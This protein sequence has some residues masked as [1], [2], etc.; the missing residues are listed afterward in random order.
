MSSATTIKLDSAVDSIAEGWREHTTIH[1]DTAA[2]RELLPQ[3]IFAVWKR[4]KRNP[5]D[6]KATKIPYNPVTG[7]RAKSN[8]PATWG[9]YPQAM[10]AMQ[11]GRFDGIAIM[12]SAP[13]LMVDLDNCRDIHTGR[14]HP[15][16]QAIIDSFQTYWEIS[17]S[18]QGVKA[19]GRGTMPTP[20]GRGKNYRKT[21][22]PGGGVE[23]YQTS[24]MFCLNSQHLPGTP[25]SINDVTE[26]LAA[27]YRRLYPRKVQPRTGAPIRCAV[28]DRARFD[29][30]K[31]YIT[32]MPN[33]ITGS[34][35]HNATFAACCECFRFGLSDAD[36]RALMQWFNSKKTGGEPWSDFELD[37]KLSDA[38]SRVGPEFGCRLIQSRPIARIRSTVTFSFNPLGSFPCIPTFAI[39]SAGVA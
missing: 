16:A 3:Q 20:D 24:R 8:N 18:L 23:F 10:R 35:G 34:G 28:S 32:K 6:A 2:L 21:T 22:W 13:Y 36:A 17:P 12:L 26:P 14:I 33:A 7:R 9:T 31:K 39:Q 15:D 19:L 5:T 4:E 27:L 1:N 37:H 11:S 25:D 30:A 38:K 29:R